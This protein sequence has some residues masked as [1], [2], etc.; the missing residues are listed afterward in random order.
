[1]LEVLQFIFSSFWV[2]IGFTIL[3]V[4]LSYFI[5]I[6]LDYSLKFKEA[7]AAVIRKEVVKSAFNEIQ[8]DPK[9]S[10][11]N[12]ILMAE[13]LIRTSKSAKKLS[14]SEIKSIIGN[15]FEIK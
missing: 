6:L 15:V 13:A 12:K 14:D 10:S 1:M 5:V 8:K 11:Y 9:I 7:S 4:I 2:W 3:L